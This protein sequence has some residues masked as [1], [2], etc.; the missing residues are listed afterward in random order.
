VG[1]HIWNEVLGFDAT[2]TTDAIGYAAK[3]I[4][5]RGYFDTTWHIQL[6]EGGVPVS[7]VKNVATS[8]ECCDKDGKKICSGK[9]TVWTLWFKATRR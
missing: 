9:P 3:R 1:V 6:V 2:V 5:D 4:A 7:E 8:S